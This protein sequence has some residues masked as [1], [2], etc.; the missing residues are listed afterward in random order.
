[1]LTAARLRKRERARALDDF[2]SLGD[3]FSS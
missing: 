1:V 3:G 2:Q